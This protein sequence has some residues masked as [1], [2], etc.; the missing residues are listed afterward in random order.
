MA[1]R[2]ERHQ[3]HAGAQVASSE[4]IVPRASI[5]EDGARLP[6]V[7]RDVPRI[8]RSAAAAARAR[9]AAYD[10]GGA[11]AVGCSGELDRAEFSTY[12][13]ALPFIGVTMQLGRESARPPKH[14]E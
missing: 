8:C 12:S 14:G 2:D 4:R 5:H 7:L 10:G 9:L 1:R 11:V 13:F 3:R 6:L